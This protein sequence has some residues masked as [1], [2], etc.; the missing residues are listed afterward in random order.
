M[1]PR[2]SE[3]REDRGTVSDVLEYF[4]DEGGAVDGFEESVVGW[5]RARGVG[6]FDGGF[7]V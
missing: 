4:A 5:A 6:V 7:E 1:E 2:L 3:A